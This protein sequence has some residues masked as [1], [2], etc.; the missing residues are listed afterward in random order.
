MMEERIRNVAA[1]FVQSDEIWGYVFKKEKHKT[2]EEQGN[3]R[4]GDAYTFV[5]IEAKSKLILCYEL[6]KRDG[7]TALAF[8]EKLA[9]ATGDRFQLTTDGFKPYLGAVEEVFGAGT[10]QAI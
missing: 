5:A 8:M 3:P 10:C 4:I 6:G 7:L 9:R 1:T 2:A